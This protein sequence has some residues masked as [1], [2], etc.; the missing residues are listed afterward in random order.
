MS[1]SLPKTVCTLSTS[2]SSHAGSIPVPH[3]TPKHSHIRSTPEA[4]DTYRAH[5]GGA[6]PNPALVH[7][8]T[9]ELR[10]GLQC[11]DKGSDNKGGA[12]VLAKLNPA[13][14]LQNSGSVARDHLASERTFL[15]YVRTSLTIA[16]TGVGK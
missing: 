12:N 15:A 11:V 13:M 3:L 8:S 14:V 7:S 10:N 6:Y 16:T 4:E 9:L 1:S 2:S 5:V